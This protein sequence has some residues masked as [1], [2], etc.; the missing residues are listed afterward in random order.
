[1]SEAR[2]I[3][4]PPS[5]PEPV[6]AAIVRAARATGVDFD[7]LLAQARIESS[8]DPAARAPT[9]SAA[10]LYQF[11]RGT[12]LETLD[13]HGASHG[14][15][16]ADAAIQGGRIG[17]PALRAQIMALRFDPNASALMAAELASDNR[18]VLAGTLG[19][20]P[21]AA[22]LYTAQ[23]LGA[24]G[25][26]SFLS[27]LVSDPERSAAALLPEAAAAN[28]GIFYVPSGA[29]RSVTGVMDLIRGK[30]GVAMAANGRS[31]SVQLAEPAA[32]TG[33]TIARQFHALSA[34]SAFQP[35][36]L[37]MAET[38]RGAFGVGGN[39]PGANDAQSRP[40]RSVRSAYA[41]L[42]AFGL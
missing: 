30:V 38:L 9:S 13:R 25:A 6:R 3:G 34:L 1:M 27:T 17:D 19:R 36:R 5:G 16:W 23:F 39:D 33:G 26:K 14:L 31:E 32:A 35:V 41:R 24:A 11:T 28:R 12:W 8:L 7:Y 2:P 18:D 20:E 40:D 29:P 37:S 10:G 4:L 15:D 21:D 22:E 42:K